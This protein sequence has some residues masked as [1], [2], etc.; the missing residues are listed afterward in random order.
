MPAPADQDRPVTPASALVIDDHPLFCD[1]LSMTLKAAVGIPEIRT[2]NRLQDALSLIDG[3][4]MPEVI[5]LDLNLPDVSGLDGL[6]RLKASVGH[7]PVIV[8][9]SMADRRIISAAIRAGAAGFVP[10]HP[11]RHQPG[12]GSRT[13]RHRAREGDRAA[14][15][16]HPPADRDPEPDLRGQTEQADRL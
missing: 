6:I 15:E 12:R 5:V 13:D 3:G 2:Q 10:K 7:T 4:W 14:V 1:A 9:S 16:T 8:V 11:G